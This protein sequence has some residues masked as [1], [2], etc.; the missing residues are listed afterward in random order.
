MKDK[1]TKTIP[2]VKKMTSMKDH[3]ENMYSMHTPSDNMKH[4]QGGDW[5]PKIASDRKTTHLKINK[6]DH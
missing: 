1:Y 6:Q 4:T 2:E 5:G 3:W